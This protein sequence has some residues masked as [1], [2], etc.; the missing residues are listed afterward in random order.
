M[1]WV[2][3]IVLVTLK[4]GPIVLTSIPGYGTE[5]KCAAASHQAFQK[6]KE[7]LR[8]GAFMSPFCIPGPDSK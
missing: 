7:L 4:D 5:A 2:L 3:L 1:T 6:S 8:G